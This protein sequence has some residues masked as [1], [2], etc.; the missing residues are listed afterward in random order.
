M[1]EIYSLNDK[2]D[3]FSDYDIISVPKW[4]NKV[5]NSLKTYLQNYDEIIIVE[6]QYRDSGLFSFLANYLGREFN[7]KSLSIDPRSSLYVA[8]TNALYSKFMK[9]T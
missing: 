7:I 8:D 2:I 9:L 4:G 6:N 1:N 5:G 3:H